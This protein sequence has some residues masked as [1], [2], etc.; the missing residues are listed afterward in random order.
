MGDSVVKVS[1]AREADF[2]C[3][4]A[5]GV[6]FEDVF[7][8]ATE[9]EA[10]SR[11]FFDCES[12]SLADVELMV[13]GWSVLEALFTS[14]GGSEVVDLLPMPLRRAL[15]FRFVAFMTVQCRYSPPLL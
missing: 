12:T 9:A 5:E 4:E 14:F 15:N 7:F 1:D 2:L 3:V 8:V 6:G 13:V 11:I 10:A